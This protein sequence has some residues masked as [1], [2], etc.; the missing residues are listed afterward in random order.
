MRKEEIETI[1]NYN[2]GEPEAWIGTR[3]QSIKTKM[4]K[5][6]IEL[7]RMQADYCCYMIPKE[8]IHIYKPPKKNSKKQK[9]AAL[10]AIKEVNRKRWKK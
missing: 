4:K 7:Y 6:G 10:R 9:E 2:M 8:W 3:M 5:L 1:I